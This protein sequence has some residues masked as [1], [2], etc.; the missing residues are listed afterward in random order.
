MQ[1]FYKEAGVRLGAPYCNATWL[2][3]YSL[4]PS[5][6]TNTSV[7]FHQLLGTNVVLQVIDDLKNT[8]LSPHMSF[9]RSY[10]RE[11]E[12]HEALL[13]Q[14][15]SNLKPDE[16]MLLLSLHR[17]ELIARETDQ[18]GDIGFQGRDPATDFRGLGLLS[19]SNLCYYALHHTDEAIHCLL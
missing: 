3:P 6:R 13:L 10:D 18:W 7:C 5:F 8:P 9:T 12:E 15:W 11:N 4:T 16:V 19:L 2:S 17:L 14:L 1:L